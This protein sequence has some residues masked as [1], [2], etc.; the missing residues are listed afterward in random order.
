MS[1][2]QHPNYAVRVATDMLLFRTARPG[3]CLATHDWEGAGSMPPIFSAHPS[4]FQA[5]W[6]SAAIP[7]NEDTV[8][9][10]N[11]LEHMMHSSLVSVVRHIHI[12]SHQNM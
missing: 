4:V 5:F 11:V 10:D 8:V 7:D 2:S 6:C 3:T 1:L 12:E 9:N